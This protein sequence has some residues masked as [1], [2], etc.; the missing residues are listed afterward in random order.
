[1]DQSVRAGVPERG[2]QGDDGVRE[3]GREGLLPC[4]GAQ[5][6]PKHPTEVSKQGMPQL[7]AALRRQ[8]RQRQEG[9]GG[10][11]ESWGRGAQ[12]DSEGQQDLL[13]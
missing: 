1:M 8:C 3:Q 5:L 2:G 13:R 11:G 6:V 10:G 12:L 7:I 9:C 4:R